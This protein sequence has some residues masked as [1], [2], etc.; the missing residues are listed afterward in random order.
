MGS[1]SLSDVG[2]AFQEGG[3][4]MIGVEGNAK[5]TDGGGASTWSQREGGKEGGSCVK[6][7]S[8]N[9]G[10]HSNVHYVNVFCTHTHA[11]VKC[12]VKHN[13]IWGWGIHGWVGH[14]WQNE[15]FSGDI[16]EKHWSSLSG[17]CMTAKEEREKE[18]FPNISCMLSLTMD[19]KFSAS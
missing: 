18:E 10:W 9:T 16:P 14:L 15:L 1:V 13:E 11:H 17:H 4:L 12:E 2:V 8:T 5:H 19:G 6:W 7:G 3:N